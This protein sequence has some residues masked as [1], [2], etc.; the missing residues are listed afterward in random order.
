MMSSWFCRRS[1]MSD[2]EKFDWWM[3]AFIVLM[4]AAMVVHALLSRVID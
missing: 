1:T 4:L 2:N 3:L